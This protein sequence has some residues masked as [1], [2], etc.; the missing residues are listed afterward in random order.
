MLSKYRTH[1]I[2]HII[3]IR[4][5]IVSI[6]LF[7]ITCTSFF[8][9]FLFHALRFTKVI[10]FYQIFTIKLKI[11]VLF[12]MFH[13]SIYPR[14]LMLFISFI[15]VCICVW[16]YYKL[17][18]RWV[19]LLFIIQKKNSKMIRKYYIKFTTHIYVFFYT[20]HNHIKK[21]TYAK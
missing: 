8:Q 5:C 11:Q 18:E 2:F 16:Q 19:F 15:Y 7:F 17:V 13:V 1:A 20:Y 10:L 6:M 9:V 14:T 3:H 4:I 21:N 12:Y